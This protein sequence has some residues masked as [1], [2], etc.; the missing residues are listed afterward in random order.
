MLIFQKL[1]KIIKYADSGKTEFF[2]QL[3][4]KPGTD[5]DSRPIFSHFF[6]RSMFLSYIKFVFCQIFGRN[7]CEMSGQMAG[8]FTTSTANTE[9]RP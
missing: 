8:G 4:P 2:L 3:K 7:S 9:R 1:G 5:S 6:S